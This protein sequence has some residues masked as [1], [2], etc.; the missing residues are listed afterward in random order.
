LNGHS[1]GGNSGSQP[2]TRRA[3]LA[4][5]SSIGGG[6]LLTAAIPAL[7]LPRSAGAA[8]AEGDGGQITVYARVSRS[9]AVT[10]YAPN[11]EMGQGTRTALP[12]I[13][14]EE[15]G[16]AWRDVTIEMADYMGGK[17]MGG[18]T[19]GASL[20][21]FQN[22]EPLRR[23]GAAGRQMFVAAAAQVWQVP[24]E[25]CAASDSVV[26]HLPS[27]RKLGYGELAARASAL[28]VPD[29]ALVKLKDDAGFRIIG[30]PVR[31]PDKAKLVVGQPLFGIDVRVPGM[32]YAVYQKGPVYDA[33]V[34]GVNAEE[35]SRLPGVNRVLVLRGAPRQMEGPPGHPFLVLDDAM[36]GG[37]AI[38]A[39]TWWHA[40]K[41]RQQLKIEWDEGAHANDSTAGFDRQAEE[42]FSQPPQDVARLDGDPDRALASAAKVIHATYSYPFITHATLEPQN[43]VASFEEGR[44]EIW[45]PTQNPG[46]G[47]TK[48]AAALGI[49]PEHITIHMSRCGGGFGRRLANDY[50]IEAATISRAIGAP[51][52]VLWSREDDLQ[53][54]FYRPGGYHKLSGGLDA[55]GRLVAWTNHVAGFARNQYFN[56]VS[57]PEDGAFPGGYIANYSVSTSRIP[58]NVPVSPLRA[59]GDNAFAF[60]FQSFLDELAHAAG[61][62]PIDLQVELLRNPLPGVGVPVPGAREAAFAPQRM[63]AVMGKV[64]EM[65]GWDG[66]HGLPHGMGLGFA[67]YWSH[68]GYV[69]QVHQVSV[70]RHGKVTPVTVWV[71]L[72]VGRHIVNPLNAENQ[73]Q[74]AILDGLSAAQ[75]QR[76]TFSA[77]RAVQSNFHDYR[78]MRNKDIPL[79]QIAFV[80]TDNAVTGLGEPAHPST[81]PAYCNAIFAASGKRV[82][83]LPVDEALASA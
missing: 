76:V 16:V 66:R 14:A 39:D 48:V 64:R 49:E 46:A 72:D 50:M 82:R 9:G 1:P 35:I 23:A 17:L 44:L 30:Q 52:K 77:G 74:G 57:V 8:A 41:A 36:R 34:K 12:M 69:A 25:E 3:F 15:L 78:L 80:M 45:A 70:D 58:F 38:I 81:I 54:G 62:D 51:V 33:E 27:G 22:W 60:V 61:R 19:S 2:L 83:R 11:P 6:L 32:K 75:G 47:R 53:Q 5:S 18:Q 71:A 55:T 59:P 42:L 68:Q 40:Q 37:V 13:F 26:Q 4:A 67:C 79:I 31:D 29:L 24:D 63:I 43:C 28:P 56:R 7:A 10:I 21:T 73:V 65:S 20:S